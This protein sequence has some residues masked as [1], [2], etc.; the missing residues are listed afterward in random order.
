MS[1][2]P[3]EL[4]TGAGIFGD[5]E[6]DRSCVISLT[7]SFGSV[8]TFASFAG[9][10]FLLALEPKLAPLVSTQ[11]DTRVFSCGSAA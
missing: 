9:S 6:M 10:I 11:V 2:E 7:V 8:T 3:A 1:L 5:K 4:A